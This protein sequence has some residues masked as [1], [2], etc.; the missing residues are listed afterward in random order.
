M[1]CSGPDM[2]IRQVRL[3][4]VDPGA[5]Y[6]NGGTRFGSHPN[7][8]LARGTEVDIWHRKCIVSP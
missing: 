6:S 2:I 1:Q 5:D 4:L 8:L 7:Y 3:Y